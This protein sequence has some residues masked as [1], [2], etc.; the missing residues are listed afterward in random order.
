MFG[1]LKKN[2]AAPVAPDPEAEKRAAKLK[3]EE[4]IAELQS[5]LN[6]QKGV[7][8]RMEAIQGDLLQER[9][10][11]MEDIR[12]AKSQAEQR[13]LAE[14]VREIDEELKGVEG[15]LAIARKNIRNIRQIL[16]E[17]HNIQIAEDG[18]VG[19]VVDLGKHTETLV[20]AGKKATETDIAVGIAADANNALVGGYQE[21]GDV[22]SPDSIIAE[23]FGAVPT[24]VEPEAAGNDQVSRPRPG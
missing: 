5:Q 9:G 1:W 3:E 18:N 7:R 8:N 10:K 17:K 20:G 19:N 22:V 14:K 21:G 2:A 6:H 11:L 16:R 24:G 23:A 15:S 4:S 12:G 13:M